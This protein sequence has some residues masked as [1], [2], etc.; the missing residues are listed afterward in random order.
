MTYWKRGLSK[1]LLSLALVA[2]LFVG[3]VGALILDA[4]PAAAGK[5]GKSRRGRNSQSI[6]QSCNQSNSNST[7]QDGNGNKNKTSQSN[8]CSNSASQTSTNS[9]NTIVVNQ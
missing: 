6:R 7:D 5:R 4:D 9:G 8:R 2:S 1:I 3:G